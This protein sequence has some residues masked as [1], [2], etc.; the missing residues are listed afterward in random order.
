MMSSRKAA[1]ALARWALTTRSR[2]TTTTTTTTS[3]KEPRVASLASSLHRARAHNNASTSESSAST[4]DTV[5]RW[6]TEKFE[7]DAAL[8]WNEREGPFAPLHAMNP[9]RL[10]FI[11]DVLVNHFQ[12]DVEGGIGISRANRGVEGISRGGGSGSGSASGSGSGSGSGSTR[13]PPS[14]DAARDARPLAGLR[15]LDVGCGGGILCES[16]ARMGADVTG[17]DAGKRNIDIAKKHASLDPAIDAKITYHAA[18]AEELLAS[19][20]SFDAVLSMEVVEHVDNPET[21]VKSLHGLTRPGGAVVMSTLNRTARSYALAIVAAERIMGWV[22]PGTHEFGKFL[23]PEE[24]TVLFRRA[25]LTLRE[26]A[27]MRYTPGV[28]LI[29]GGLKGGSWSLS[30]GDLAV[31]YIVYASRPK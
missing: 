18:P 10:G 14:A 24:L 20:A 11:R 17:I 28:P 3:A 31:N 16:L 12:G 21:F 5:N 13:S 9:A 26:A 4:I 23:T 19:G 15:V 22:P 8:W 27:G 1:S 2:P 7:R 25:G 30:A 6:E 29:G